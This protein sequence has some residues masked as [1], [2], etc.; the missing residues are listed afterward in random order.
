MTA[1]VATFTTTGASVKVVSIVQISGT[2]P[3]DFTSPVD[4]TVTAADGY[5]QDYTVT[6]TVSSSFSG[7]LDKAFGTSGK[8]TTPV[9]SSDDYALALGIQSDGKI[10]V[11][12]Y[13]YRW[14]AL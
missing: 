3:N 10:V 5:K 4:Y 6:V 8:V 14:T 1:L 9:G 2:T 12:G 7:F 13:S 11:A